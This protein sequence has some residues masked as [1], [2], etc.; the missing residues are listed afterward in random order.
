MPPAALS[1]LPEN[2]VVLLGTKGGPA[3]RPGSTNP[4][5]TLLRLGGEEIVVDCGLGVTR[6]LV[7]QGVALERLAR[8]FITHLHSDHYLELGPLLHTAWT[9]GLRH[10]VDLWGPPGLGAYWAA[11]LQA[12]AA[13]D[14]ASGGRR[15]SF[16]SH[17]KKLVVATPFL[18]VGLLALAIPQILSSGYGWVQ[19]ATTKDA[20]LTIPL[21]IVLIG[22]GTF[23]GKEAKFVNA[24]LDHMA[25]EARPDAF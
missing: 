25:R 4:T 2:C 9:A 12:M 3:I 16:D 14:T 21:W 5:A 7:D 19:L 18:L 24:V 23:D 1:P 11:F 22:H 6:A 10:P 20:L 8:I 13:A 15:I 17:L